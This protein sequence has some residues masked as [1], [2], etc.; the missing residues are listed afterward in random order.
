MIEILQTDDYEKWFRKLRDKQAKSRIQ[1]RIK[2]FSMSNP[3]DM[4][5]LG[6]KVSELRIDYGPGYRVYFYLADSETAVLL[7]GG[8]KSTQ[9]QDIERAR[10][11]VHELT[12]E[13][14]DE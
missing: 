14:A 4:R 8:D 12:Q 1:I 5:R 11:L 7:L 6:G 9:R 2:R 13:P 10:I 3:G